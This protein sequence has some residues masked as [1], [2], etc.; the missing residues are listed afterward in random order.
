ML[1]KLFAALM[2]VIVFFGAS[3]ATERPQEPSLQRTETTVIKT[4]TTAQETS[5]DERVTAETNLDATRAEEIAL[6][7]LGLTRDAVRFDRTELDFAR[8]KRVYEVELWY[9]G[10]EYDLVIDAATGEVL[11]Q[12]QEAERR[13]ETEEPKPQV[14]EPP[15]ELTEAQAIEIALA[16]AG[17]AKEQVTRLHAEKDRDDGVWI[18]E[19]EFCGGNM[20]YEYEVRVSDGK[21]I[22]C[23]KEYDD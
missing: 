3:V 7:T 22:D 12:T 15:S 8:G 10:T 17:L 13:P 1:T 2:T 23:D 18:Y 16:H 19:I 20:E 9:D 6:E 11:H 4:G 5:S 14:T 21:I